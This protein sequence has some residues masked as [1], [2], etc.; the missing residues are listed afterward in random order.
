MRK[1]FLA[2]TF[3][4]ALAVAYA[5]SQQMS[6]TQTASPTSVSQAAGSDAKL[7]Q[8]VQSAL[9]SDVAFKNVKATVSG[10][11]VDLSGTVTS[12]PD[13]KRA[14]DAAKQIAGVKSVNEHL[15]IGEASAATATESP[16][17]QTTP[18]TAQ[19]ESQNNTA[20]S[21]A[22]NSGAIGTTTGDSRPT[23]P[24]IE[25]KSAEGNHA[26]AGMSIQDS[27][28]QTATGTTNAMSAA[29]ASGG[30]GMTPDVDSKTLRGEIDSALKSDPSLSSSQLSVDVTDSE[31]TLNGSVP[32]GKEKQTAARIAQSYAGNRRVSDKTTVAGRQ[33][34]QQ[35]P[36]AVGT[37]PK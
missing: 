11:V 25:T 16:A 7:Q 31:I 13:Q 21:I 20:G 34:N 2:A 15:S 35:T 32:T 24:A 29:P 28:N 4:L 18:Q 37:N 19:K 23:N 14:K 36:N 27:Q 1:A 12:Q 30:I 3:V 9:A 22:G 26:P 5:S 8:Q 17:S 6:G 10:G 33:A